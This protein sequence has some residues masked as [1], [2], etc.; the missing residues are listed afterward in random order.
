MCL[1]DEPYFDLDEIKTWANTRYISAHETIW[2][3]LDFRLIHLATRL[4]A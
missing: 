1:D 3:I 4:K 2:G